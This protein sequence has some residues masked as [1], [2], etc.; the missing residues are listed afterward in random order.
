V[1]KQKLL[2]LFLN[3]CDFNRTKAIEYITQST[4]VKIV[5]ESGIHISEASLG[6]LMSTTL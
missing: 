6:I 1:I 3:F 5:K 4:F 2:R